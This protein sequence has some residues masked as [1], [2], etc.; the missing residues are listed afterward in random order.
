MVELHDLLTPVVDVLAVT[1]LA[2]LADQDLIAARLGP[3]NRFERVRTSCWLPGDLT[4]VICSVLYSRKVSRAVA[5]RIESSGK[6]ART[7]N[8]GVRKCPNP[9]A[10]WLVFRALTREGVGGQRQQLERGDVA[11]R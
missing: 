10:I 1:D 9:R 7:S 11:H 6:R 8:L 4:C 2:E 3:F 5:L